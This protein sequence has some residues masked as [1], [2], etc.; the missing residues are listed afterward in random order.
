MTFPLFHPA[1]KSP[2]RPVKISPFLTHIAHR[3]TIYHWL[4]TGAHNIAERG[5]PV[6]HHHLRWPGRVLIHAELS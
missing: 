5:N 2:S 4:L 3:I 1:S 6:I